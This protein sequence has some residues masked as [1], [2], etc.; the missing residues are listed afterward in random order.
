MPEAVSFNRNCAR[1]FTGEGGDAAFASRR[2]DQRVA[3]RF[4]AIVPAERLGQQNDMREDMRRVLTPII[5]HERKG[6]IAPRQ[7]RRDIVH[8]PPALADGLGRTTGTTDT[9]LRAARR[10]IGETELFP[11][12]PEPL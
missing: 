3:S 8:R 9:V 7:F 10:P 6:D 2:R 11:S 4:P 12:S 1:E 5:R